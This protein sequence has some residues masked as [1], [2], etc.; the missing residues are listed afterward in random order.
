MTPLPTHPS[1]T[2][3]RRRHRAARGFTFLEAVLAAALL[4]I[5][6]AGVL[7]SIGFIWNLELRNRRELAAAEVANRVLVAYLDDATSLRDLPE[8]IYYENE[9]YRWN[10]DEKRVTLTDAQPE[11]RVGQDGRSRSPEVF[12]QIV[13]IRVTAWHSEGDGPVTFAPTGAP[14]ATLDRVVNPFGFV[15]YDSLDRL[16]VDPERQELIFRGL[17]GG[18][19]GGGAS[20]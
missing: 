7:G 19:L 9:P 1:A 14:S 4:G 15:S 8:V 17:L 6:A 11:A 16:L 13:A 20:R 3:R 12:D 18:N 2:A 10:A 5:I